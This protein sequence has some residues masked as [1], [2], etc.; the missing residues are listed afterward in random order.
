MLYLFKS[1]LEVLVSS[2]AIKSHSRKILNALKLISSRF[3][4]GVATK[5]KGMIFNFKI[6]IYSRI[7]SIIVTSGGAKNLIIGPLKPAPF[8]T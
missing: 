5:Y 6:Q 2:H 1:T 3:P 8:E 4:I 7:K